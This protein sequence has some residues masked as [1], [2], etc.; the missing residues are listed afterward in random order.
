MG[1]IVVL[2]CDIV[3]QLPGSRSLMPL[4]VMTSI[5]SAPVVIWVIARA[6]HRKGLF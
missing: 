3:T 6:K 2:A 4:N 5:V 1:S